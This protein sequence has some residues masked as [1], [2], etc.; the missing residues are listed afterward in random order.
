M[1]L[2]LNISSAI[3]GYMTLGKFFPSQSLNYFIYK[4]GIVSTMKSCCKIRDNLWVSILFISFILW[5]RVLREAYKAMIS[6][7]SLWFKFVFSL[8]FW[9]LVT[10][11]VKWIISVDLKFLALKHS[12]AF[13]K[14]NMSVWGKWNLCKLI[15]LTHYGSLEHHWKKEVIFET[16][17]T[18]RKSG[19]TEP[20]TQDS[21][22]PSCLLLPYPHIS[23]ALYGSSQSFK[24]LSWIF[25]SS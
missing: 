24:Y 25:L 23:P 16:F 12:F 21:L 14:Q 13:S 19:L 17:M 5:K 22:Q 18:W 4:I 8:S 2:C 6:S 15:Y 1:A 10:Y 20:D 9:L 7:H 3:E 11:H